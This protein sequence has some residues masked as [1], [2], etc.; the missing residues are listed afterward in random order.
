[1]QG[2]QMIPKII[3]QIWV[4]PNPLPEK[5]APLVAKIGPMHSDWVHHLWTEDNLPE[6]T[7]RNE[8]RE[9]LRMPAERS[10]LLRL[11]LLYKF[12]GIYLDI[13]FDVL[14]R[15]DPILSMAPIVVGNL[16]EWRVNNAFMA[17]VPGH[18]VMRAMIDEAMPRI[19]F[20]LDKEAS[21][22]LFVDNMLKPYKDTPEVKLLPPE[23]FYVDVPTSESFATHYFDRSWKDDGGWKK[24]AL[25]A[26]KRLQTAQERIREL[27]TQLSRVTPVPPQAPSRKERGRASMLS[28]A[29]VN[30]APKKASVDEPSTGRRAAPAGRNRERKAVANEP[31]SDV[32][33]RIRAT[34]AA[35]APQAPTASSG[36]RGRLKHA[37]RNARAVV[38]DARSVLSGVPTHRRHLPRLLGRYGL[39]GVAV[40]VNARTIDYAQV[41]LARW[42]GQKLYL[43]PAAGQR[44]RLAEASAMKLDAFDGRY[45]VIEAGTGDG[46]FADG[47]IDFLYVQIDG[48]AGKLDELAAWEARVKAGGLIACQGEKN[49]NAIKNELER[50]FKDLGYDS[51]IIRRTR[52]ADPTYYWQKPESYPIASI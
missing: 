31:S 37:Y 14:K 8:W 10:D 13:D 44:E 35:R 21:G 3:H 38:A 46:G 51:S 16:K 45:R 6:D 26:E 1:M 25:K 43:V 52:D 27:E 19:Y 49:A 48:K 47:S 5:Y 39:N 34:P 40:M 28:A 32:A 29:A 7:I 12:G 17:T 2:P 11:E 33:K 30:A 22:S 20:G 23:C 42:K 4:G 18:P 41:I 50:F 24:S 36:L 9:R 15:L